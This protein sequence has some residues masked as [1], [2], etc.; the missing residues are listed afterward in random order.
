MNPLQSPLPPAVPEVQLNEG[1]LARPCWPDERSRVISLAGTDWLQPVVHRTHGQIHFYGLFK[2]SPVERLVG[3]VGWGES[4]AVPGTATFSIAAADA[5]AGSKA[6]FLCAFRDFVLEAQSDRFH[7]LHT[8]AMISEA[9]SANQDF[10]R[11]GFQV[12][13]VNESFSFRFLQA[14]ERARKTGQRFGARLAL[15]PGSTVAVP[16]AAHLPGLLRL[17]S[18]MHQLMPAAA[19]GAAF[20]HGQGRIAPGFDPAVSIVYLEHGEVRGALLCK[21]HGDRLH[22]PARVADPAARV[23]SGLVCQWMFE[24]VIR[25][26]QERPPVWI[27]VSAEPCR[28]AETVRLVKRYQGRFNGR[29]AVMQAGRRRVSQAFCVAVAPFVTGLP[30]GLCA[31]WLRSA[32]E[33]AD[34]DLIDLIR[35]RRTHAGDMAGLD[36]Y[37]RQRDAARELEFE[38][39]NLLFFV[40]DRLVACFPQARF[41]TLIQDPADWLASMRSF[42]G[43]GG[44]PGKERDFLLEALGLDTAMDGA[45]NTEKLLAFWNHQLE[46]SLQLIPASRHLLLR[47]SELGQEGPLKLAEFLGLHHRA[48]AWPASTRRRPHQ[49]SQGTPDNAKCGPTRGM[50]QRLCPLWARFNTSAS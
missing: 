14:Q 44:G 17:C 41:V 22:V 11:A 7:S 30:A 48:P 31:G 29:S 33:P 34:S 19:L 27:H 39:S 5:A 25:L 38:S 45:A 46:R 15:P 40:L 3:A 1:L 9:G 20:G 18:A 49:G 32:L 24:G 8:A 21:R 10:I 26:L 37:L 42:L 16:A 13:V 6:S 2:Q 4:V 36:D 23:A 28:H 43:R 47:T 35:R 50:I 12:G